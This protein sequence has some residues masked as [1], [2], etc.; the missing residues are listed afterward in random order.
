M[1]LFSHSLTKQKASLPQRDRVTRYANWNPVNCSIAVRKITFLSLAVGI[2]LK[3]IQFHRNYLYLLVVCSN[4]DSIWHRFRY[5]KGKGRILIQRCLRDERTSALNNLG[6]GS[7]LARANGAAAQTAA[8][9]LHALTYNWTRGMQLANTPPLQSTTPGL[10]PVSIH[11]KSPPVRGSKHAITAHYS[12][13]W[14]RKDE[15]LSRPSW[16]TCS[17][18]F[19]HISGHL[20]VS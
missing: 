17:G 11:Q 12:I 3:V 9:Q 5:I 10:H 18:R 1:S 19:T 15:R 4:N 2:T 14:P 7:W 16:L 13:Y 6:S 20:K 8:I